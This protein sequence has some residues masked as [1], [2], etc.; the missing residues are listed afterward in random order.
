[1]LTEDHRPKLA[2]QK[3]GMASRLRPYSARPNSAYTTVS[4]RKIIGRDMGRS[5]PR[6]NI[7]DKES[8]Y[9]VNLHLKMQ[10]GQLQ[11]ENIRARTRVKF[12][13]QELARAEMNRPGKQKNSV[14]NLKR[15]YQETKL[16]LEAREKEL[17][18]LQH[19]MKS[20]VINE[21]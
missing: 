8:L 3:E 19:T 12:L 20:T 10:N 1:M 13:E 6:R 11:E 18:D 15:L 14:A 2:V 21:L 5:R 9:D 7:A 4:S 16:T 17:E